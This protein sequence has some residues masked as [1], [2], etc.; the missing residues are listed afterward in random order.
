MKRIASLAAALVFSAPLV[1]WADQPKAEPLKP[2]GE[3]QAAE[4]GAADNGTAERGGVVRELKTQGAARVQAQVVVPAGAG[5]QFGGIGADG[6]THSQRYLEQ[7][8]NLYQLT[9]EQKKKL[10]SVFE[11]RDADMKT[12]QVAIEAKRADVTRAW[13]EANKS[14]NQ[15]AIAKAQKALTALYAPMSKLMKKAHDD[16]QSILTPEQREKLKSRNLGVL[17]GGSGW[18]A[19]GGAGGVATAQVGSSRPNPGAAP[20]T[21][22]VTVTSRPEGGVQVFVGEGGAAG[23]VVA[24]SMQVEQQKQI[25]LRMAELTKQAQASHREM[26]RDRVRRQRELTKQATKLLK[27]LDELKPDEQAKAQQLMLQIE[28]TQARLQQTFG[29]P[30]IPA[31]MGGAVMMGSGMV[32]PE[33]GVWNVKTWPDRPGAVEVN[34][35]RVATH[36]LNPLPQQATTLR[37]FNAAQVATPGI[38]APGITVSAA[39]ANDA[40][41]K[42]IEDLRRQIDQLRGE[43]RK[44][45]EKK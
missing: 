11:K 44:L 20:Q 41:A 45:S 8:D 23:A 1:G 2:A 34:G 15:E 37:P 18:V 35:Q 19:S 33:G 40:T 29:H 43:V 17:G 26:L 7:L 30:A 32:G 16:T 12:L 5:F 38:A 24:G 27:Q 13:E 4:K 36:N 6:K 14:K 39:P 3:K 31:G 22:S 10:L 25:Q 28:Q 21:Q 9:D 42:A